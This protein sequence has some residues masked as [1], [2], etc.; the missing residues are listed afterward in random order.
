MGTLWLESRWTE[1]SD[2]EAH[3]LWLELNSGR[4]GG[5]S[6]LPPWGLH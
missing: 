6:P 1:V 3:P 2:L 4:P 5:P